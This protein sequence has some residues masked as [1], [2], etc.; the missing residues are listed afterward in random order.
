MHVHSI[1]V[2][3]VTIHQS[4]ARGTCFIIIKH[5]CLEPIVQCCYDYALGHAHD[6]SWSTGPNM[7]V[8]VPHAAGDHDHHHHFVLSMYI[9][10][11]C[12]SSLLNKRLGWLAA[13][14]FARWLGWHAW[15]PLSCDV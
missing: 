4:Y 1:S 3:F 2:T 14:H 5:D 15:F 8:V 6:C 13:I 11:P 10:I 7:D 12:L 9:R